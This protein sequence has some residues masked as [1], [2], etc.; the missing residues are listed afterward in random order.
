MTSPPVQRRPVGR[1]VVAGLAGAAHLVVGFYYLV[2]GLVIPGPVLVPLWILWF[3]L[4]GWLVR[5][6][7][8]RSWWTPAVP[9]V[10]AAVLVLTVVIGDV[11]FG[12]TA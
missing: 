11:V 10:A 7:A 2:G 12:W 9:V 8:R 1:L 6:A 5:L 3:A 4:A